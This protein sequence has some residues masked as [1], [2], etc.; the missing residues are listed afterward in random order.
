MTIL[1]TGGCKNGKSTFAE[2]YAQKLAAGDPMYYIATMLAYDEEDRRRIRRHRESRKGKHFVTIEQP[3][4]IAECLNKSDYREGTYLVDSVTA[5]LIN[6]MYSPENEEPDKDAAKKTANG[7]L[8]LAK[9]AKNA[10]FVSDYIFSEGGNY[11]EYTEEYMK[12]L[13]FCD[14][15]LAA[16]CD[17]VVEISA[18]I[19]EVYKGELPV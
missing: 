6:E 9:K 19:P 16:H 8:D 11:S 3:K 1:I 5:L 2:D 7:L 14:K 10:I 17:C 18:G 15:E 12:G 13:A 4:N